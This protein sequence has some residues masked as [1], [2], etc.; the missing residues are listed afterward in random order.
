[1]DLTLL[2]ASAKSGSAR[3]QGATMICPFRSGVSYPGCTLKRH[4]RPNVLGLR[5]AVAAH[6][7]AKPERQSALTLYSVASGTVSLSLA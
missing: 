2:F 6:L 3:T 4:Y 7:P 1:M 5:T